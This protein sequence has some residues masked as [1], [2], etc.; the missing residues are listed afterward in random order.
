MNAVRFFRFTLRDLF[1]I[2]TLVALNIVAF[3]YF[4]KLELP[5]PLS[6]IGAEPIP[7]KSTGLQEYEGPVFP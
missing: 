2:V 7:D 6:P 4:A 5:S 3:K 1:I